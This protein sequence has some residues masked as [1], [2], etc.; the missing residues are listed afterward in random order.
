MEISEKELADHLPLI[1]DFVFQGGRVVVTHGGVSK[2]EIKPIRSDEEQIE[3]LIST[4]KIRPTS[5]DGA[6]FQE[7][8]FKL[9]PGEKTPLQ[10]LLEERYGEDYE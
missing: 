1:L 5:S 7:P 9:P 2:I 8:P 6:P 3:H 4:G 10:H